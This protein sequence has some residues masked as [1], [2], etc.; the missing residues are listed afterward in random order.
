MPWK[1]TFSI[2]DVKLFNN[3]PQNRLPGFNLPV[4]IVSEGG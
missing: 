1:Q 4:K 3:H 2:D